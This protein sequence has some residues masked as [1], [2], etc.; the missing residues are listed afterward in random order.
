MLFPL[1]PRT[2]EDIRAFCGRFNEGIRVEYKRNFD[3]NVRRNMPKIVSSFAN[4]LGGVLILGVNAVNGVP[5]EPIE[6][7]EP[8]PRE[9]VPLTVENLCIQ[10]THPA[11]F[12][13][14]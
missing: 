1:P 3:E 6:G 7:F 10:N 9:E 8:E 5:Q 13:K 11:I 12:P 14:V 2:A 4:S